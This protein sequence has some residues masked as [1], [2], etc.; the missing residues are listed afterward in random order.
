MAWREAFAIHFG[1]GLFAGITLGNWVRLLRDNRFA[2]SSSCFLRS[3]AIS[4]QSV[5]NSLSGC[6]ENW[7]MVPG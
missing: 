1:P 3:M 7:R 2:G 4:F 6:Y 5:G